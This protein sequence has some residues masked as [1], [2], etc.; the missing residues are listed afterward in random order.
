MKK[1]MGKLSTGK[2]I[3]IALLLIAIVPATYYAFSGTL[4]EPDSLSPFVYLAALLISVL[5]AIK[6]RESNSF[7]LYALIPLF[8]SLALLEE[9]A[10]GVELFDIQPYY[11]EKYNVYIRDLHGFAGRAYEL[12]ILAIEGNA[13][14]SAILS[15]FVQK[16]IQIAGLAVLTVGS[17]RL[18][19]EKISLRETLRLGIPILVLLNGAWAI[20]D[21][22]GLP[23]DPKNALLLGYSFTRLLLMVGL[24]ILSIL[25]LAIMLQDDDTRIRKLVQPWAEL[26]SKNKKV[27]YGVNLVLITLFLGSA[28]FQFWLV[29]GKAPWGLEIIERLSPLLFFGLGIAVI[30]WFAISS[31]LGWFSHPTD[32]Y[33]NGLQKFFDSQPSFIYVLVSLI[34]IGIAQLV[35][36]NWLLLFGI[37]RSP[38]FVESNL[39]EWLEDGFEL[40]AGFEL[41]A[42]GIFIGWQSEDDSS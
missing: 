3:L 34:L 27:Y 23:T 6:V 25:P 17:A 5:M 29:A 9:I 40:T 24:F 18:Y 22:A 1:W 26:I 16:N 2:H 28:A 32:R 31:W 12:L 39:F 15:N 13:F 19:K 20:I 10:Y 37:E 8:C 30:L 11:W 36:K 21:M 41:I 35:D 42:A 33:K 4:F 38:I 7:A 14:G